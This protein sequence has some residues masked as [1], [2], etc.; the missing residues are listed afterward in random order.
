MLGLPTPALNVGLP[1]PGL[2]QQ[3]LDILFPAS[4]TADVRGSPDASCLEKEFSVGCNGH[5]SAAE[6]AET[7]ATSAVT[8]AT[9]ATETFETSKRSWAAGRKL[10]TRM[11]GILLPVVS[12]VG[13]K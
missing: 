7:N 10:M 13:V 5:G 4:G 9:E 1:R 6:T 8:G 12:S 2:P 11:N 3:V